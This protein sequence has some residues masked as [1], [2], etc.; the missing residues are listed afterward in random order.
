MMCVCVCVRQVE[1]IIEEADLEFSC[2]HASEGC[3]FVDG[4][5][6]LRQ[7]EEK[8]CDFRPVKCVFLNCGQVI[9]ARDMPKHLL[10]VRCNRKYCMCCLGPI[11]TGEV[12]PRISVQLHFKN[13]FLTHN[14]CNYQ[15][16]NDFLFIFSD[17]KI[18]F[19]KFN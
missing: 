5:S 2:R 3:E 9:K 8:E 7:H 4:R 15:S 10:Q 12:F 19:M 16:K 11:H 6:E 18:I 14:S 13:Q 17:V 1:R